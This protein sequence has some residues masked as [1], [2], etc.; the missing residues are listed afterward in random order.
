[1][2]DERPGTLADL[3]SRLWRHGQRTAIRRSTTQAA[4]Q[5]TQHPLADDLRRLWQEQIVRID[6]RRPEGSGGQP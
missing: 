5:E 4:S 6:P 2:P 1:M 3:I